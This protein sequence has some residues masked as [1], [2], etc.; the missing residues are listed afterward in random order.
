MNIKTGDIV[1][2]YTDLELTDLF[3]VAANNN[4]ITYTGEANT[5]SSQPTSHLKII[6]P[7]TK[8]LIIDI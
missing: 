3:G 2:D 7:K 8:T 1:F 4:R 6:D 5:E